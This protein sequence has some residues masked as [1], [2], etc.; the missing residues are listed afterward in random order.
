M[1]KI[2]ILQPNYIPWKGVFDLIS[3]VDVFVFYDDVPYTVKD[4]RSRNRIR[5]PQGERWLSVPVLSKG[6]RFQRICDALID[7][8]S[9]WQTKHYKALEANYRK[10]R[11]FNDYVYLLEDIYL[12]NKWTR[13]S[14]L[15]I[16]A[17]KLLAGAIGINAEWYR[18]SD[19]RQSGSKG[20]EKAINL[21]KLLGC[22]YF[23]NGPSAKA[24]MNASLFLENGIELDYI[25]Y[26]YPE[27]E[28][29]HRPFVHEVTVLD[30][31][32]NCGPDARTFVC[33]GQGA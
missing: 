23:I 28:Q 12:N 8:S 33:M 7:P 30:V 19:L 14:D 25:S 21:C 27:Y 29:L 2:A 4:W 3:R 11:Y 31:I 9:H 26:F 22:D 16:F 10:A 20:G 24:F 13:I 18:S 6:L 15:N 17:T 5:T 1:R 32:F